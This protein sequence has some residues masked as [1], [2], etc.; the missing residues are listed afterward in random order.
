MAIRTSEEC[1]TSFSASS[2]LF[3]ATAGS[4]IP[5]RLVTRSA[6][7]TA[8]SKNVFECRGFELD[9]RAVHLLGGRLQCCNCRGKFGLILGKRLLLAG[10]G[11]FVLPLIESFLPSAAQAG[12]VGIL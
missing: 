7:A 3:T 1:E 9:A 11:S 2:T 10:F 5:W 6:M 8:S 4:R 12:G